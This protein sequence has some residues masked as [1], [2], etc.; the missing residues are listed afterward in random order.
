[1]RALKALVVIMSV[2]IVAGLVTI[3]V[4]IA[5]RLSAARNPETAAGPAAEPARPGHAALALPPGAHIE[6]MAGVGRN[7]VLRVEDGGGRESLIVLD[8]ADGKLVETVD[9]APAKD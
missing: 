6:D 2:I 3:V 1:M 8:P 5:H 7:L 4:T 9:L